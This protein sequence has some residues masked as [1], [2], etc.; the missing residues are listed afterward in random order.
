MVCRVSPP[1][2]NHPVIQEKAKEPGSPTSPVP[3]F[4]GLSIG[5]ATIG[6]GSG[7]NS[8]R[9]SLAPAS[10]GSPPPAA[11][12]PGPPPRPSP[13][14]KPAMGGGRPPI[15]TAAMRAADAARRRSTVAGRPGSD[16]DSDGAD[17]YEDNDDDENDPFADSNEVSTPKVE[18]G[19]PQ[20]P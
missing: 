10:P 14:S 7:G 9:N 19:N 2:D 17:S 8:K 5:D 1:F 16:A 4:A 3:D 11:A 12:R 15:P 13:M 18:K 20:W 6:S